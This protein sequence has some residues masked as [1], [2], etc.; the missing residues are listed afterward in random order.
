MR[1]PFA[2][3]AIMDAQGLAPGSPGGERKRPTKTYRV[4][5]TGIA[6]AGKTHLLLEYGGFRVASGSLWALICCPLCS[7]CVLGTRLL[8]VPV[9]IHH[10][11]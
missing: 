5:F 2:L 9:H 4:L 3:D 11:S 10:S 1:A 8:F 7:L 6:D